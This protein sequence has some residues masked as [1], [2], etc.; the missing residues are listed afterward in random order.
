MNR[1]WSPIPAIPLSP[2]SRLR[3]EGASATLLIVRY[4]HFWFAIA[5]AI[6]LVAAEAR[7][8]RLTQAWSR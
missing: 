2:A 3:S 8:L 1:D 6:G 4:P 5:I 7:K